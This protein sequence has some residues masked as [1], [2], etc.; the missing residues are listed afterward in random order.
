MGKIIDALL[1]LPK[2]STCEGCGEPIAQR[3]EG[4]TRP[5]WV[6]GSRVTPENAPTGSTR[7]RVGTNTDGTINTDGRACAGTE[8]GSGAHKPRD[9]KIW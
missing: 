5:A 2:Y 6:R 8:D 3:T 9:G 1:G 7:G 4:T